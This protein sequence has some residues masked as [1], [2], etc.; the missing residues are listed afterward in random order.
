[1]EANSQDELCSEIRQAIEDGKEKLHGIT[2]A[3]CT[4]T[5]GVLYHKDKLW[6]PE[7]QFTE[8]IR[9]THDQPACGH[10]GVSRTYE[11]LKREYYW[12]GM[13]E[14]VAQYVRNCYAC[15]RSKAPRHRQHGL[16]QPLPIP[17]KR[18]QDITMDFI[19]GLP[20]SLGYNAIWAIVDRLTK[21]RHYVPCTDDDHGT[22]AEV[23]VEMLI[24][25]LFRLHGLPASIV[26]DRGPQF[27]A[28]IWKSFC[29]RLGITA[30]LST[31]FHPETDGQTER[32]NQ[33][34]ETHLRTYCNYMQ[35]DWAK[36]ISMAEFAD[37]NAVSSATKLT[38]FFANRGWHPRMSFSPDTTDYDSTR[39]RLQAVKAEDITDH[40]QEVLAFVRGNMEN[41]QEAMVLQVNKHRQEALF[42]EGDMVFLSSK[43]I[44]TERPCKKL[45]DKRFG[46]FKITALVG[47]SYRLELPV[48]MKVH[49]VFHPSL[50]TLAATDP[51]PGQRNPP[52]SPT[53]TEG[54]EEWV[55]DDI[56]KSKKPYGHLQ[57]Q[58]K[59]EG[60]DKDLT[61]YDAGDG[62]FDNAKDVVDD[63]HKRYP[64][65]PR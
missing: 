55:V 26:S 31:S 41:A 53:V 58:V 15:H 14:T 8:V 34:V 7:Q 45:D 33:D 62:E 18:W 35:D 29:K 9:E 56:L 50:L 30:K 48:T 6:V 13:R 19:T 49:D 57:Y 28:T 64:L 63:F 39:K 5:D 32:A 4:V 16:L 22:S 65:M 47:S 46:P 42:K 2:L 11:L 10:P 54:I 27:I 61:W 37:N 21:E 59:W 20:D 51:L 3:K 40:M 52:P 17:Q 12:R 23:V 1:M 36:W 44:A 38:P 43:N 60:V 24:K 25:E